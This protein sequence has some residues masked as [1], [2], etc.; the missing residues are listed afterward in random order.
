MKV[1]ISEANAARDSGSQQSTEIKKTK[2]SQGTGAELPAVSRKFPLAISGM[3]CLLQCYSLDSSPLSFP[4][5]AHKS[6]LYVHVSIAALHIG[7]C[8]VFFWNV[9]WGG[10]SQM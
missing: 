2:L 6:A 10:R 8:L 9:F 4:H 3:G 5:C 1:D 7:I